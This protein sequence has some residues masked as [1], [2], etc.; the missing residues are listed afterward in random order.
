L[1][2]GTPGVGKSRLANALGR[3]LKLDVIDLGVVV[4]AKKLYQKY[5]STAQSFVIDNRKVKDYLDTQLMDKDAVIATHYLDRLIPAAR[6]RLAIVLRL[7]PRILARRLRARD[8]TWMKTWENIESELVDVCLEEAVRVLG[9]KKVVQIDT[10]GL[11]HSNVLAKADSAVRVKRRFP[12]TRVDWLARY[13]PVEL[14]RNLR[15]RN[16]TS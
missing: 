9:K 8:W 7:D 3:K 5:D 4:K 11:T 15:W 16:S 13:D 2:I 12:G 1:I 6:V 10:T 14:E